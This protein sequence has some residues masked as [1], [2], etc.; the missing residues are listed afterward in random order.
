MKYRPEN[1]ERFITACMEFHLSIVRLRG[2]RALVWDKGGA[3]R[4]FRRLI[5]KYPKIARRN[6]WTWDS[7][8]A[9]SRSRSADLHRA[10]ILRDYGK[11]DLR[12]V[13]AP[14]QQEI[15]ETAK[16]Q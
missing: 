12:N 2:K 13:L 10:G 3:R 8:K 7:V 1:K 6:G 9:R 4:N 16:T 11:P 14:T 5:K 15:A